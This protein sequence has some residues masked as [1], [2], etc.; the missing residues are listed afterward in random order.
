MD[1]KQPDPPRSLRIAMVVPP[2]YELPP[3]GYGGLEQVCS[4]LVDALVARGHHVT[5]FGAGSETGTDSEF[6]ATSELQ[7]PRLGQILPELA[8]LAR[9]DRMI[10]EDSF[11][12]V[13][14]HTTAGPLLAPRRGVPTVV[15]VHGKPTGELG[16]ILSGV[17]PSVGLVAI[18]HA[19][20]RLNPN[21]PWIA[22][23][24]HGL[25]AEE[26]DL[27]PARHDGP[28][29]WLARFTA[30]KGP[31]LAVRACQEA[32]LPLVLAGKC[33]EPNER[34]YLQ[35]AVEPLLGPETTL[36]VNPDRERTVALLRA[37]RCLIMP[38]RWDEPFGM[39]MLEAMAIGTPVVALNRG[40]VPEL[41]RHGETGLICDDPTELPQAL[42]EVAEIDP[43]ACVRRVRDSFSADLMARGYERVYQRWAATGVPEPTE[44]QLI[45][46]GAW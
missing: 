22:T 44:E 18:S 2:W 26:L 11:D 37:A 23:V 20:R 24:Y 4:A 17:D 32:G 30:D 9:T 40:A 25:P 43:M 10:A 15:T 7:H 39:V 13:H 19:Q 8:H 41:V 45:P 29:L 1:Q 6:V 5:L 46:S 12:V 42:R 28:V 21:L 35:D 33:N 31:D 3:P 14:D 27:Q 34:R 36:L 16:D 38:I